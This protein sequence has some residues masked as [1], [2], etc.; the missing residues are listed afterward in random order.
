MANNLTL[1]QSAQTG[2]W[3][4]SI[5][6]GY[7][8]INIPVTLKYNN[9]QPVTLNVGT[10]YNPVETDW[11]T[12]IGVAIDTSKITASGSVVCGETTYQV[13]NPVQWE[14]V[15]PASGGTGSTATL[16]ISASPLNVNASGHTGVTL[17]IESNTGWTLES[18]ETWATVSGGTSGAN[19][20]TRKLRIAENTNLSNRTVEVR[21]TS[22]GLQ[23]SVYIVQSGVTPYIRVTGPSSVSADGGQITVN[24]ESNTGWTV[25]VSDTSWAHITGNP[26]GSGSNQRSITLDA[27]ESQDSRR[28]TITAY[29]GS[30]QNSIEIT[31]AGSEIVPYIEI[32]STATTESVESSG[33]TV[34]L[35][36]DSNTGWTL[37]VSQAAQEY[38][39]ITSPSGSGVANKLMTVYP[40]AGTDPRNIRV[41]AKSNDES[42][43]RY[44]DI[45]QL[46]VSPLLY[47]NS[48]Y[49]ELQS[50]DWDA[51]GRFY[52]IS[53]SANIAWTIQSSANWMTFEDMSGNPITGGSGNM[54]GIY[55][56]FQDNTGDTDRSL[57]ITLSP[58]DS[59]LGVQ[60]DTLQV[61]QT[62]K[63]NEFAVILNE[64]GTSALT[65]GYQ[66]GMFGD[67][68]FFVSANTYWYFYSPENWIGFQPVN[69]QSTHT[70]TG[71]KKAFVMSKTENMAVTE[72]TAEVQLCEGID[73]GTPGVAL[74][75]ITITQ[76]RGLSTISITTPATQ[77]AGSGATVNATIVSNQTW[78]VDDMGNM[79]ISGHAASDT[80]QS[81]TTQ[82]TFIVPAN[83]G[84][85]AITRTIQ[86]TTVEPQSQSQFTVLDSVSFNQLQ[87]AQEGT[88]RL[89]KTLTAGS[90]SSDIT[91]EIPN[92]PPYHTS[93]PSA[94]ACSGTTGWEFYVKTNATCYVKSITDWDDN[95]VSG[96]RVYDWNDVEITCGHTAGQDFGPTPNNDWAR[97]YFTAGPNTQLG[98]LGGR[99]QFKIVFE[100]L[101]GVQIFGNDRSILKFEQFGDEYYI[102]DP[103][104]YIDPYDIY[105][106]SYTLDSRA[107]SWAYNQQEDS[108]F[109]PRVCLK[110]RKWDAAG[111]YDVEEEIGGSAQF[112]FLSGSGGLNDR[113]SMTYPE[114]FTGPVIT[115]EEGGSFIPSANVPY[116]FEIPSHKGTDTG[117]SR[118]GD[119]VITYNYGGNVATLTIHVTQQYEQIPLPTVDMQ[120]LSGSTYTDTATGWVNN[121]NYVIMNTQSNPY[122]YIRGESN[123]KVMFSGNTS[124]YTI[125]KITDSGGTH[126]SVSHYAPFDITGEW[127]ELYLKNTASSGS[128]YDITIKCIRASGDANEKVL[129]I[130]VNV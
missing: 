40:N 43:K 69:G 89:S 31:Q 54:S 14:A 111:V 87:P 56:V 81:G 27:N 45:T 58:A 110:A 126:T 16:S 90:G 62:A 120:M 73:I 118:S 41:Y 75:R 78:K 49:P 34:V 67:E 5:K 105:P 85:S 128:S 115:L 109:E 15:T 127:A 66:S 38:A 22:G 2:K 108:A 12:D 95:P 30:L 130:H 103:F 42:I 8:G 88:I 84:T 44:I 47:F 17:T 26:S 35:A 23:R 33:D 92:N 46:G 65:T 6:H 18:M 102:S 57:T 77:V 36:V 106:T 114:W 39:S 10:A 53:L 61:T 3:T 94:V 37:S 74:D 25:S 112:G 11:V 68:C 20:A 97:F 124:N 121:N 76:R 51:G 91:W 107:Y 64:C 129:T 70:E 101:E 80:F 123:V 19:N 24:I 9:A 116:A 50:V 83:T 21:I 104:W 98:D 28:V 99:K 122:V 4:V 1:G 55:L 60:S 7:A 29:N 48:R 100:T 63:V 117:T 13:V 59:S 72:R 119:V 79:T 32:S 86:V 52:S 113:I 125:E 93:P 82:L 71:G 96:V